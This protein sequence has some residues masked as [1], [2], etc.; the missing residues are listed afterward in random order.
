LKLDPLSA[1]ARRRRRSSLP[2]AAD[3]GLSPDA[4]E[5]VKDGAVSVESILQC[6]EGSPARATFTG[7]AAEAAFLAGDLLGMIGLLRESMA[8]ETDL[9]S[10]LPHI[11][12]VRERAS[13]WE[14]AALDGAGIPGWPD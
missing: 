14:H 3:P 10:P 1:Q 13:E 8:C 9:C 7:L 6:S 12:F 2:C 4:I 5:L 11:V